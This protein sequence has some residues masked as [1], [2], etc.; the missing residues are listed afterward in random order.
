MLLVGFKIVLDGLTAVG[1]CIGVSIDPLDCH[2]RN[3]IERVLLVKE[4]GH[5]KRNEDAERDGDCSFP[6]LTMLNNAGT[7]VPIKNTVLVDNK[8]SVTW[9][10]D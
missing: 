6:T 2:V 8:K 1:K 3:L 7:L 4:T 10:S 9:L 5:C